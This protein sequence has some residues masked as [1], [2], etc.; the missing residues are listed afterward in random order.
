MTGNAG[1]SDSVLTEIDSSLAHHELIKVR[2]G[3]M[4]RDDRAA[5]TTAICDKTGSQLVNTIGHIAIFYRPSKQ[6][7]IALPK[8]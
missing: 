2:L 4:E 8:D 3:G 7:L 5:A 1:L 6:R